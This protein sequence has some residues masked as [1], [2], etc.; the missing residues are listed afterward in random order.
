MQE[1]N[2]VNIE[3]K[4]ELKNLKEK[5]FYNFIPS[6]IAE[7][8][9]KLERLEGNGWIY[10][11]E[12]D[13]FYKY[14][15]ERGY[16]MKKD[17]DY[18]KVLIRNLL[19]EIREKWEK[20]SKI[21]EIY[22][23]VKSLSIDKNNFKLMDYSMNQFP[24]HINLENGMLNLDKQ[25]LVQHNPEYYSQVQLPVKYDSNAKCNT[26]KKAMESWV[27]DVN[28][29]MFLQEYIGYCLIPDTSAQ[30]AVILLGSGSNGKSTF[31]ETISALFGR[32]N[33]SSIPLQ[34]LSNK[35]EIG[36]VKD[37]LINI[38]SDIDPTYMKE[39]GFIKT[40]IHGEMLRGEYKGGKSFDFSP[41]TRLIFSAN[42]LPRVR[43]KSEGWYRSFEFV[44]FPNSFNKNDENY[45]PHLK[46]KLINEMPG[47]FNWAL[48][49]LLRYKKNRQFTESVS[50][51]REK[52]KYKNSNDTI[53]AFLE[54]ETT[55]KDNEF[56]P[57]EYLYKQYKYYC[58]DEYL[59]PQSRQTFSTTLGNRGFISKPTYN[60]KTGKSVRCYHGLI[61]QK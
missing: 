17:T 59:K 19:N 21:N 7:H 60:K 24:N 33:L 16:W 23:A 8:L 30:L 34:K 13:R 57:G 46:A 22:D 54:D 36:Y 58:E 40:L 61:Y 28:S 45:D 5:Q 43:D 2:I 49:G 26:W 32:E 11:V 6:E 50:L 44:K 27:P 52:R 29:R 48:E 9:L 37:K 25:E 47:I 10:V 14:E 42:E 3:N 38:C 15:A 31:L 56:V 51:K 4:I 20:R 18:L 1:H 53:A 39:T 55:K 12:E 35:F 41:V